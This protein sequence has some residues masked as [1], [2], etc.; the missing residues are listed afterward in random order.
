[1]KRLQLPITIIVSLVLVGALRGLSPANLEDV[2]YISPESDGP[3]QVLDDL[4]EIEEVQYTKAVRS[5]LATYASDQVLVIVTSTVAARG[6]TFT[7]LMT[8][9]TPDDYIFNQ[10]QLADISQPRDTYATT[11]RTWTTIFE[12]PADFIAGARLL[13]RDSVVVGLQP[14][15]PT[16]DYPLPPPTEPSQMFDVPAEVVRP[17]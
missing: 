7:A 2:K 5:E 16:L 3:A 6:D 17:S 1:M 14:P 4:I 15:V 12:L 10:V 13:V 11:T 8:I 9:R